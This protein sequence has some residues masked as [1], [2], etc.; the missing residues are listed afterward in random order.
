MGVYARKRQATGLEVK[1]LISPKTYYN[2]FY[3]GSLDRHGGGTISMDTI[4]WESF[5]W[6]YFNVCVAVGSR[7][8]P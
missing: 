5:F 1:E 2:V 4:A 6:A 7:G 3:C 8:D